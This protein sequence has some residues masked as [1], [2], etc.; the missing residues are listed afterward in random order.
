ME[1]EE[2]KEKEG[3]ALPSE[4]IGLKPKRRVSWR[5]V[6]GFLLFFF[7]TILAVAVGY[8]AV[9]LWQY[10]FPSS[11]LVG[12]DP[13][14]NWQVYRNETYLLGLR[15]PDDWESIEVKEGLVVFRPKAGENQEVPKDY[16]SLQVFP[17]AGREQTACEK[18]LQA[19]SFLAN[20]IYGEKI[21]TPESE[22]VRFAKEGNDFFL[23][24]FKYGGAAKSGEPGSD[25]PT[26][27]G[28]SF[29][30]VFEEMGKSLRFITP[31][32]PDAQNP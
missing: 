18:D 23:T 30:T 22:T 21:L 31:E 7:G 29:A 4:D 9:F 15:Y 13:Y 27:G 3:E 19:C 32:T 11:F 17:T 16:I 1:V 6:G 5:K 25:S 26:G 12:P 28:A 20:G 24:W 10:Y 2:N 8:L 14:A